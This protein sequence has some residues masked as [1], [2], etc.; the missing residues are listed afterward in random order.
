MCIDPV[1]GASVVA[2]TVGTGLSI[3]DR[4]SSRSTAVG[5]RDAAL[6]TALTSTI[7]SINELLGQVY[8]ANQGRAN[9]ER[10]AAATESF[11]I[12]RARAEAKGTATAVAADAGVGGVSFANIL[13]D[14]E[15]REGLAKGKLDYNFA[16]KN[17]QIADDNLQAR[18]KGQAQINSVLNAAVNATPV[19]SATSMW[20][21]IGGDAIGAGLKVGD[22]LGLFDSETKVDPATGNTNPASGSGWTFQNARQDVLE[23]RARALASSGR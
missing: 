6:N 5:N 23:V 20:A 4:M 21:G 14:F 11:D 18:S 9:Q 19:P 8:N 1:T 7:P 22:K 13:G 16:T 12:L 17:Q 10:D 15:M 3:V 2:T